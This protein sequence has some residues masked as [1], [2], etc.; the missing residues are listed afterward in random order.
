MADGSGTGQWSTSIPTMLNPLLSPSDPNVYCSGCNQ[1]CAFQSNASLDAFVA[2]DFSTAT[3]STFAVKSEVLFGMPLAG[4]ANAQDRYSEQKKK[5]DEFIGTLRKYLQDDASSATITV[6][7]AHPYLFELHFQDLMLRDGVLILLSITLVGLFVLW[8]TRSPFL[9]VFGMFHVI[10]SFPFAYFF[11]QFMFDIGP[12]G[13]LNFMSIFI[14]LG[15]GADD[16]FILLDA[17]KQ[18]ANVITQPVDTAADDEDGRMEHLQ[19]RFE[20][21]FRRA[22]WAMLVSGQFSSM[23]CSHGVDCMTKFSRVCERG[24]LTQ[25][26]VYSAN[27]KTKLH[28]IYVTCMCFNVVHTVYPCVST[29]VYPHSHCFFVPTAGDLP[30]DICSVSDEHCQR[31]RAHQD[32]WRVYGVHGNEQGI[33]S[34]FDPEHAYR[35]GSKTLWMNRV[36]V[37]VELLKNCE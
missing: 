31:C 4:Y 18:S 22:A 37:W 11:M 2:R 25:C 20:W 24:G 35:I 14:I 5:I 9:T 17:W 10:L 29:A 36:E 32:F 28:G 8:H 26:V 19:R 15:I 30:D 23:R 3:L 7:A 1:S 33:I 27:V 34:F 6:R 13:I 21:T 12:M 16:I